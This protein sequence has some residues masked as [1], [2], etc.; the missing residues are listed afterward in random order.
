MRYVN[1]SLTQQDPEPFAD[2]AIKRW[3][4]EDI[5]KDRRVEDLNTNVSVEQSGNSTGDK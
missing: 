2:L 5:T 1:D 4:V 3:Q